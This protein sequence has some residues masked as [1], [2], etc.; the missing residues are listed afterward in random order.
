MFRWRMGVRWRSAVR[1]GCVAAACLLAPLPGTASAAQGLHFSP[2]SIGSVF[3][4]CGGFC[5]MQARDVNGSGEFVG[6]AE[7]FALERDVIWSWDAA[8][9]RRDLGQG[10]YGLAA[11]A[12]AVNTA[13]DIAGAMQTPTSIEHAFLQTAT[14]TRDLG[15]LGGSRSRGLGMNDSDE[16]VGASNPPHT[17]LEHAFLWTP[18]AGMRDLGT[19]GGDQSTAYAVNDAGEV[20][21][22]ADPAEGQSRAFRWRDGRMTS[23]GALGGHR[24]VAV[25]INAAGEVAG[26]SL[27]HAHQTHAVIWSPSGQITDLGARVSAG[28]SE[29]LDVN[30]DGDVL[31][32]T[33]V[34]DYLYHAGR[35]INL[36][37]ATVPGDYGP[38]VLNDNLQMAGGECIGLCDFQILEPVTPY[39]DANARIEYL[40]RWT[41]ERVG[42]FYAGSTTWSEAAG[43]SATLQFSGRRVWWAAPRGRARGR[44]TVYIDGAKAAVVHLHAHRRTPREPVFQHSFHAIGLHTITVVVDGAP[45]GHARVDIDAFTVSQL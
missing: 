11:E 15:T 16:V 44:A 45:H 24:S 10:L 7:S 31:V 35:F 42:D 4:R 32:R 18:D 36:D 21:G 13:G 14:G 29:A 28:F 43:A 25:A 23:L 27:T 2:L 3:P 6:G 9:G 8:R 34:A 37:K 39:D 30:D 19:L 22:D 12:Y 41:H 26:S 5:S 1:L 33:S 17:P 20:V 40:G 38:D